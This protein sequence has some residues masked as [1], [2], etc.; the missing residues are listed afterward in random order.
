MFEFPGGW[1][2]L[3]PPDISLIGTCYCPVNLPVILLSL[4][5][6]VFSKAI[7]IKDLFVVDLGEIG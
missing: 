6:R 3:R 5:M 7:E 2:P 4:R 1:F